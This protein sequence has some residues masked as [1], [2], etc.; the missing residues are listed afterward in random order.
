MV[1]E[2][3]RTTTTVTYKAVDTYQEFTLFELE[4]V[5]HC[6]KD[7]APGDDTVCYSSD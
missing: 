4:D 2:R 5:L 6:L 1:P 3:V 7:T